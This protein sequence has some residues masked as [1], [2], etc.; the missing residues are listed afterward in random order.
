MIDLSSGTMMGGVRVAGG[1]SWA[2]ATM[3]SH[4][5]AGMMGG[6]WSTGDRMFGLAFS[7]TTR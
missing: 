5:G 7:F 1:T 2:G 6:G 3:T 4:S